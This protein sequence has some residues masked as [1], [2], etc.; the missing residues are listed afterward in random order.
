MEHR[1]HPRAYPDLRAADGVLRD[2]VPNVERFAE[3]EIKSEKG[4]TR[5]TKRGIPP[6]LSLDAGKGTEIR[7]P[8]ASIL[9]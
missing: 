4:M 6:G 2:R 3:R 8:G 7:R 9:D 1:N 5:A